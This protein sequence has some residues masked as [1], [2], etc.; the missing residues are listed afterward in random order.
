VKRLKREPF[1][2]VT[3]LEAKEAARESVAMQEVNEQVLEDIQLSRTE[4]DRKQGI[5][6]EP[7][8]EM[9]LI[10]DRKGRKMA[11][12]MK[13]TFACKT[14]AMEFNRRTGFKNSHT[15]SKTKNRLLL[16]RRNIPV[17]GKMLVRQCDRSGDLKRSDAHFLSVQCGLASLSQ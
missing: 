7:L 16:R 3:L 10:P 2:G 9:L 4:R 11:A 1:E 6:D 17:F 14:A 5:H 15:Q 8:A 13:R 12:M